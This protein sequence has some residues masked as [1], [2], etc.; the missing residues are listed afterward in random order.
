MRQ[1]LVYTTDRI[2]LTRPSWLRLPLRFPVRV[3][4]GAHELDQ[5][6]QVTGAHGGPSGGNGDG[7]IWRDQIGP[8]GRQ[9]AQRVMLVEEPHPV[10]APGT[11]EVEELELAAAPG[12]ERMRHMEK[13]VPFMGTG[14]N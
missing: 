8:G 1:N 9:R 5:A 2:S 14:C 12:M 10:F 13:P 11:P 7:R 6:E 3:V 4:Q